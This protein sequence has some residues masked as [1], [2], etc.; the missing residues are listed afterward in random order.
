M[1][2]LW[3]GLGIVLGMLVGLPVVRAQVANPPGLT[4]A[5]LAAPPGGMALGTYG[6]TPFGAGS[7]DGVVTVGLKQDNAA[8]DSNIQDWWGRNAQFNVGAVT[9]VNSTGV[10]IQQQGSG[11]VNG[12]AVMAA[13]TSDDRNVISLNLDAASISSVDAPS[14]NVYGIDA[15][16]GN[17]GV[18]SV[19][20][21][22]VFLADGSLGSGPVTD[23]IGF[24]AANMSNS[25][26]GQVAMNGYGLLIDN[27]SGATNN[28]AI[29]TGTGI[30]SFGD[31]AS[32][33]GAV[34]A[35]NFTGGTW[36]GKIV[37]LSGNLTTIGAFNP[38][39]AI[40]SSSTWTFPS[41]GGTLSTTTGTVTNIAT[42]GPISGG[43]ITTTGTLSLLVN[44]DY[45]FTA[46]QSITAPA[47]STALTLI[48]GTQ[49]TSFPALSAT[50]TWNASGTTFTGVK[51]IFTTTASAAASLAFDIWAGSTPATILSVSKT[52]AVISALNGG[53]AFG[54]QG[55]GAGFGRNSS[56]GGLN[57][58]AN[59]YSSE[60]AAAALL[61]TTELHV[62]STMAFAW[63]STA[64]VNTTIDTFLYRGGAAA[65]VQMGA[66]A[67]G[68]PV[69]QTFKAHN[70]ITGTDVAGATL[71]LTSGIGTG[72]GTI[73]AVTIGTPTVGSTGTTPQSITTRV[74]IDSSGLLATGY[75]SSDGTVGLTATCTLAGITTFVVK[76]GLVTACS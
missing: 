45:A 26:F 9:A 66:N 2:R 50:Q 10:T 19:G 32:F 58:Y 29:K 53:M 27:Q 55:G 14:R 54:A 40:P 62:Q 12:L 8:F 15:S 28:Y 24:R 67:N 42:T 69:T 35:S 4:F 33:A 36:Q 44:V 68:A 41:G 59:T 17:F 22:V 39:F 63:G 11:F 43:T 23:V 56:L 49:T 60:G 51:W 52:G 1:R 47:G 75:K 73:S 38:T 13:T 61:T 5:R 65:T 7:F 30:H 20:T 37:T 57:L 18:G 31:A 3:L 25:F 16:A 34:T 48:G 72:A 6:T 46:G 74:T 76:N 71:N 64:N 21:V 70:G